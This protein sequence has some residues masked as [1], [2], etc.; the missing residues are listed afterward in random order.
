MVFNVI[1]AQF[2][3]FKVGLYVVFIHGR[4]ISY[5]R[6]AERG[7][8]MEA[9]QYCCGQDILDTF[10]PEKQYQY[11]CKLCLEYFHHFILQLDSLL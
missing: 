2:G 1:K 7:P 11:K 8:R 5:S 9:K 3:L 4:C 6:E 10:P